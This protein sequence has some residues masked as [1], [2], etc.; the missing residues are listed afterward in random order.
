MCN[1]D[2]DDL[3]SRLAVDILDLGVERTLV[4]QRALPERTAEA[5]ILQI[6]LDYQRSFSIS[7]HSANADVA[8]Y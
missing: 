3:Q 2:D 7:R 8:A 6:I 4:P 1:V 5:N